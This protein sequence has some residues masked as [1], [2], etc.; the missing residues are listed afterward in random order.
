MED[1]ELTTAEC[2]CCNLCRYDDHQLCNDQIGRATKWV[3][4]SMM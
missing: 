2:D 4:T 3:N 1:S